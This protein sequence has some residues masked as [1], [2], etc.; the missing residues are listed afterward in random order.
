MKRWKIFALD[1][2]GID[3]ARGF[4]KFEMG[5]AEGARAGAEF[6]QQPER[7]GIGRPAEQYR[8]EAVFLCAQQIGGIGAVHRRLSGR[9]HALG[10]VKHL[11]QST[12]FQFPFLLGNTVWLSGNRQRR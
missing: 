7:F 3:N 6:G 4:R 12:V 5:E 11:V 2:V 1:R 8:E 10:A 9:A